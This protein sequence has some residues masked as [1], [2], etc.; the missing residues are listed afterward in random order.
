MD[1]LP[2]SQAVPIACVMY[3]INLQERL[4]LLG[5]VISPLEV[6]GHVDIQLY[7]FDVVVRV[8]SKLRYK[9]R[10]GTDLA[11]TPELSHRAKDG[12]LIFQGE[13][14]L[15]ETTENGTTGKWCLHHD[16][17]EKLSQE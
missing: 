11:G 5:S 16:Y 9:V 15:V 3:D 1:E 2:S 4:Y 10:K 12:L 13:E 6:N 7:D 8:P 14:V 17:L